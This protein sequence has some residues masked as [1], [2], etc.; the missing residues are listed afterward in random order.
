MH[1]KGV[2]Q[3]CRIL[4]IGRFVC[5]CVWQRNA[6]SG[7]RFA[8]KIRR[9]VFSVRTILHSLCRNSAWTLKIDKMPARQCPTRLLIITLLSYNNRNRFLKF[10]FS[11]RVSHFWPVKVCMA[12]F[13]ITH[14]LQTFI[15]CAACFANLQLLAKNIHT[16]THTTIFSVLLLWR[17]DFFFLFV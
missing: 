10:F 13:H 14:W 15:A 16:L 12:I 5:V 7:P 1:I 6:L 17:I 4:S 9:R 2:A 3:M 8:F 11:G